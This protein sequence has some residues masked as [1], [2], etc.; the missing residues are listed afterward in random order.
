L[1]AEAVDAMLQAT[2]KSFEKIRA[3]F[4]I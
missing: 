3:N 1:S 4:G 2:S